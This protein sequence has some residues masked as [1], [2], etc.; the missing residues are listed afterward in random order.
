MDCEPWG[1]PCV[2][3]SYPRAA[4]CSGDTGMIMRGR[5]YQRGS[6]PTSTDR[7]R[8]FC[9]LSTGHGGPLCY[10]LPLH[11]SGEL[12]LRLSGTQGGRQEAG[13]QWWLIARGRSHGTLLRYDGRTAGTVG[14][15]DHGNSQHLLVM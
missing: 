8:L 2:R 15:V 5:K 11:T 7:Q 12:R 3:Q 13:R 10:Y 6:L 1:E 4:P 14:S 9:C